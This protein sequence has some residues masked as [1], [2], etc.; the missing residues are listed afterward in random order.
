MSY[1]SCHILF[2]HRRIFRILIFICCIYSYHLLHTH[3]PKY[4]DCK[5]ILENILKL[6]PDT[7]FQI[8]WKIPL[9]YK[10]YH[11]FLFLCCKVPK[12]CIFDML[13]QSGCIIDWMGIIWELSTFF[14][15]KNISCLVGK[16]HIFLFQHHILEH[17]MGKKRA[18][19]LF[20]FSFYLKLYFSLC[21]KPYYYFNFSFLFLLCIFS[22]FHHKMED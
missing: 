2:L 17:S 12:T 3:I 7:F 8:C 13:M 15:S 6:R 20:Y 5:L 16:S 1:Q 14:K 18:F 22:V 9:F 21:L 10:S 11:I 19:P 4:L